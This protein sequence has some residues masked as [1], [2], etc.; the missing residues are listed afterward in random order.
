VLYY[1]GVAPKRASLHSQ[2]RLIHWSSL[3]NFVAPLA[4]VVYRVQDAALPVRKGRCNSC[5]SLQCNNLFD[6]LIRMAEFAQEL[7]KGYAAR[8]FQGS[9]FICS[10]ASAVNAR[11]S[12]QVCCSSSLR[13]KCTLFSYTLAKRQWQEYTAVTRAVGDLENGIA[14]VVSN[15]AK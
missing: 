7:L 5:R 2:F 6:F 14:R 15:A 9:W 4:S 12:S 10:S 3:P 13:M 11:R 1:G 8:L